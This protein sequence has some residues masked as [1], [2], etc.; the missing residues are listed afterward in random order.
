MKKLSGLITFGVSPVSL[1]TILP[2]PVFAGVPVSLM[3]LTWGYIPMHLTRLPALP[4]TPSRS[5]LA[6]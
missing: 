4:S 3:R 5:D 1:D 2:F 6:F